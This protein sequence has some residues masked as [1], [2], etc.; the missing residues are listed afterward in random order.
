MNY[1]NFALSMGQSTI[2]QAW[3]ALLFLFFSIPNFSYADSFE[4]KFFDLP[5]YWEQ[6]VTKSSNIRLGNEHSLFRWPSE[7]LKQVRCSAKRSICDLLVKDF[8]ALNQKIKSD[9]LAK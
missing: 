7:E 6:A 4:D 9:V 3:R 2:S 5:S 1:T 8:M